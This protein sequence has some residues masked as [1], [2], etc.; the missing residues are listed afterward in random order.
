MMVPCSVSD[1]NTYYLKLDYD[2]FSRDGRHRFGNMSLL[3]NDDVMMC[4]NIYVRIWDDDLF[5][6]VQASPAGFMMYAALIE[7][8][9]RLY[10]VLANGVETPME[11]I[12]EYSNFTH[13]VIDIPWYDWDWQL[14]STNDADHYRI[15]CETSIDKVPYTVDFIGRSFPHSLMGEL[16]IYKKDQQIL[17]VNH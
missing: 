4:F 15:S 16:S 1:A 17:F 3:C 14:S 12:I 5:S 8:L 10:D 13:L 7:I 6:K 2:S 11:A 9:N